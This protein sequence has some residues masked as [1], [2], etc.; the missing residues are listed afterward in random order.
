MSGY[1]P[2]Q[3][4]LLVFSLGLVGWVLQPFWHLLCL[5]FIFSFTLHPLYR[6]FLV[7]TKN[8]ENL[9]AF[10]TVFLFVLFVFLPSLLI[11]SSLVVQGLAIS[12]KVQDFIL[13]LDL[14][15]LH[16]I[17]TDKLFFWLKKFGLEQVLSLSNL[18]NQLAE[19]VKRFSLVVASEGGLILSNI[20][21]FFIDVG[22]FLF[23][24]FFCIRDLDRF[25][26][27]LKKLS[28]LPDQQED[29]IIL[30]VSKIAKKVI[31]G[32]LITALIQGVVGGIGFWLV[33]FPGIFWG[34]VMGF[35]SLIP[36]VGTALVWGPG[37][38]YLFLLGKVKLG[39][40]L[41]SWSAIFMGLI[42]NFLR[43]YLIGQGKETISPFFLFLAILGGVSCFGLAGLI[44]GPVIFTFALTMVQL[45]ESEFKLELDSYNN[46]SK[47]KL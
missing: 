12:A 43:P 33:G 19:V 11:L 9:A 35:S 17:W 22:L 1:R 30:S 23:I 13:K 36:V 10:L 42:D 45:Y 24:L 26:A 29:K 38:I 34:T 47:D 16:R 39:L 40:F 2:F 20:V 37:V 46:F 4:G 5:A 3:I 32:T 7:W 25:L 44:Y 31:A 8:R 6:N 28:P 14:T 21:T 27:V 15:H 18:Q 41:L